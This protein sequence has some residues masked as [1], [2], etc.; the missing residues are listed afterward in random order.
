MMSLSCNKCEKKLKS[1]NGLK[2]HL[3]THSIFFSCDKCDMK[4][5]RNSRLKFHS[6]T[7]MKEEFGAFVSTKLLCSSDEL[8]KLI[9]YANRKLIAVGKSTS[10]NMYATNKSESNIMNY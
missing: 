7:H 4:F 1:I 2:H 10:N 6:K 5:S 8:R 3:K 9:F